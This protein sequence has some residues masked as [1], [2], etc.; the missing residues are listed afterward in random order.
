MKELGEKNDGR[1][2][3][4]LLLC[5]RRTVSEIEK[6][7][8]FYVQFRNWII[9]S[10]LTEDMREPRKPH[11]VDNNSTNFEPEFIGLM[12]MLYVYTYMNRYEHVDL[13]RMQ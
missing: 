13:I 4:P 6:G 1:A 5:L 11:F 9:Y 7:G 8:R 12:F 3:C 2:F 10:F